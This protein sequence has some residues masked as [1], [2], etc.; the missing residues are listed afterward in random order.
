MIRSFADVKTDAVFKDRCPKGFPAQIFKA[1][2][3][4]LWWMRLLRSTT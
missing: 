4:K 2:R 1:A 3:R